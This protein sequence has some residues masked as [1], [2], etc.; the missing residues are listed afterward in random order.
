MGKHPMCPHM[1]TTCPPTHM[2]PP[3]SHMGAPHAWAHGHV[4]TPTPTDPCP[5]PVRPSAQPDGGSHAH[6]QPCSTM[7]AHDTRMCS[8]VGWC[9]GNRFYDDREVAPL[10]CKRWTLTIP[11]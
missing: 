8:R 9:H 1:G 11:D 6:P 3:H 5:L 4:H 10:C 2:H 7:V